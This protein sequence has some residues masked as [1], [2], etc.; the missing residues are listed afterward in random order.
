[1]K[2]LATIIALLFC[3]F[4]SFGN[5]VDTIPVVPRSNPSLIVQDARAWPRYTL[6]MPMYLDT[7]QADTLHVSGQLAIGN[8]YIGSIIYTVSDNNLWVRKINGVSKYWSLVGNGGQSVI[9]PSCGL[10]NNGITT[11]GYITYD[12]T[13]S[14]GAVFD[15]KGGPFALCCDKQGRLLNDTVIVIQTPI[16]PDNPAFVGIYLGASG[17][18]IVTGTPNANPEVPQSPDSCALL[19]S[20]ILFNAG[21]TAPAFITANNPVIIHDE[22]YEINSSNE[23]FVDT[24]TYTPHATIDTTDQTFPVHLLHDIKVSNYNITNS[25]IN[26]TTDSTIN[27]NDYGALKYYLKVPTGERVKFL[28]TWYLDGVPATG[29]IS[30]ASTS[31][32]V[33]YQQFVFPTTAWIYLG[34]S[35]VNRLQIIIV[36][37]TSPFYLDWI[38]LQS[39]IP[40]VSSVQQGVTS[41]GINGNSLINATISQP[42]GPNAVINLPFFNQAAH[43][44][45]R[46]P[47]GIVGIP[48][49][50]SIDLSQ[51]GYFLPGLPI[52]YT[53]TGCD[54]CYFGTTGG[55]NASIP[56]END[57]TFVLNWL[58]REPNPN[59]N[60]DSLIFGSQFEDS[61]L[62]SFETFVGLN[63]FPL[64]IEQHGLG[65][66]FHLDPINFESLLSSTDG[67]ALSEVRLNSNLIGGVVQFDLA[68]DNGSGGTASV[69]GD[70]VQGT[71]ILGASGGIQLSGGVIYHYNAQT[72]T[73]AILPTD[74]TINCLSGTFTVTLLT[75]S[76]RVGQLFIIKNSGVGTITLATTGGQTIDG[77]GTKSIATTRSLMVQSDGTNWI[78]VAQF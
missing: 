54:G 20:Y 5:V 77:A 52:T 38:Q 34:S 76:G 70:A 2:R 47:L 28:L 71:L 4:N 3:F 11:T 33:G 72:S 31:S 8:D 42:S 62:L 36:T 50:G 57:T 74:Y 14:G 56:F 16:D 65:D 21:Q 46:Q 17:V 43:T 78:I 69:N 26:I 18:S 23:W 44:I 63:S 39:G 68:S 1:M 32:V 7:L 61:A 59:N 58:R 73:Y 45:F 41:L 67:T 19:L 12:S 15:V 64:H 29:P 53:A 37:G 55:N 48:S 40:P 9:L 24:V 35:Q 25:V 66:F 30:I 13:G 60:N 27:L 49:F 10:G 22:N 75:A 6:G 51:T